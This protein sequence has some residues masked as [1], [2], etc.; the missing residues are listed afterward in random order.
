[1]RIVYLLMIHNNFDQVKWI[2]NAI[3]TNDDYLII[4]IDKKAD[5]ILPSKYNNTLGIDL[6]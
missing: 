2:I 1:M 5:D 3:Y 4:H 6:T